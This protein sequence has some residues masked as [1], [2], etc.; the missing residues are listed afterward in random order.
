MLIIRTV[1]MMLMIFI[2]ILIF[3]VVALAISIQQRA[4]D[5]LAL[6]YILRTLIH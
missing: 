4:T 3:P 5:K 2:I 6:Y 1:M